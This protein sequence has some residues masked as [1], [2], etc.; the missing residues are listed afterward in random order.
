MV[1]LNF[2]EKKLKF[3]YQ[4]NV[5]QLQ[6]VG[7]IHTNNLKCINFVKKICTKSFVTVKN[8]I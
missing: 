2:Q 7:Y 3:I 1:V 6:F 4:S 5:Q 8:Q